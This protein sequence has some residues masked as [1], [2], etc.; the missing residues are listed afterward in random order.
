MSG[1]KSLSTLSPLEATFQLGITRAVATFNITTP[2]PSLPVKVN[3][4]DG[5]TAAAVSPAT[6]AVPAFLD[7]LESTALRCWQTR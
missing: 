4:L 5:K 3:R 2:A 7:V 1:A 6:F